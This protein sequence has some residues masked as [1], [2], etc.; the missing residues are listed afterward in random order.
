PLEAAER[1]LL[2]AWFAKNDG[3]FQEGRRLLI[4]AAAKPDC[5]FPPSEVDGTAVDAN[6]ALRMQMSAQ[7][8]VTHAR[9]KG[10][11][12]SMAAELA[13]SRALRSDPSLFPQLVACGMDKVAADCLRS[14][15]L[16]APS[17][18]E[19]L[20]RL[21][22][23]SPRRGYERALLGEALVIGEKALGSPPDRLAAGAYVEAL[24][25]FARLSTRPHAEVRLEIDALARQHGTFAP[26]YAAESKRLIPALPRLTET[27][28]EAESRL[29]MLR[30]A[31]SLS[32][33][34]ALTGAYP[35]ALGVDS[36]PDPFTGRP[37]DYRTEGSGFVLESAGP[38]SKGTRVAWSFTGP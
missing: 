19:A 7:L 12:A 16:A 29:S 6:T 25:E 2:T 15:D 21:D 34:R 14:A 36:P 38:P 9:L 32:R 27:A 28:V 30:L 33:H 3:A 10:D 22:P 20:D 17:V 1:E 23:S 13:M 4:E 8:L 5:R 11:G 18:A 37:F 24:S 31:S 35:A 26:A